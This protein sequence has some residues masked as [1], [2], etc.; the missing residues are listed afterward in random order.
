MYVI[1]A[2]RQRTPSGDMYNSA[3]LLG[4]D[5]K[6]LPAVH[7]GLLSYY[8]SFPVLC[9]IVMLSRFVAVRLAN[10]KS[11]TISD[12]RREAAVKAF[13]ASPTT[14]ALLVSM[15]GT[16]SSGAAGLTLTMASHAFLMEPVMNFGLEAQA[17]GRINRIG[18]TTTPVIERI[19]AADTIEQ[20]ILR[21]A[22][23]KRALQRGGCTAGDEG[24]KTAEVEEI[25]G[26]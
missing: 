15:R 5:G 23:K 8:K 1:V 20:Q 21:L 13:A 6:P 2:F 25:F 10:P 16:S 9:K 17:V 4:K 12:K 14:H 11:I 22:E 3:I 24:V 26:L 7:S 19:V 18:Q